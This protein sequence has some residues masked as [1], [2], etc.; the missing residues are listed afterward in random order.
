MD[1]EKQPLVGIKHPSVMDLSSKV[2][3]AGKGSYQFK[4]TTGPFSLPL[5]AHSIDWAAL[6]NDCAQQTIRVTV[7]KCV[8]GHVKAAEPPG[9]LEITLDP[10]ESTHNANAASG[11]FLYE[12][13]VECNS[14]LVFP[15]ASAWSGAIA[16]P[17]PGSVVKS[18]EFLR[19]MP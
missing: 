5:D 2:R 18:A 8:T 11:G 12:I 19:D 4:Y 16:D 3:L 6:N 1:S 10:G 14:Q 9:P 13:Q 7:F 17:I 15:Y